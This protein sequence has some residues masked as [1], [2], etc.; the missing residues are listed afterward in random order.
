MITAF[1]LGLLFVPLV[2]KARINTFDKIAG[3]GMQKDFTV[4]KILLVAIGIG[5]IL[6]FIEVQMGLASVEAKSFEVIGIVVGG[7]VFGIGMAILGYCPGTL[8]IAI[9]EG[10]VD[11][12]AGILGGLCAGLVFILIYP[13]LKNFI[14]PD[15]GEIDLYM[16]NP[17]LTAVLVI[18]FGGSLIVGAFFLDRR[19]AK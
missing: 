12:F 3:F 15:L 5:S 2:R 17:I 1:L 11:A 18:A 4:A 8:F 7:I 13:W 6:F 19:A 14:G 16:R 10:A 9:G